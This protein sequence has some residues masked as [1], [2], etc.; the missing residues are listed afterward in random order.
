[1]NLPW[2]L[3]VMVFVYILAGINYFR[4]P[5]LYQ[6]IIPPYF[7]NPKLLNFISGFTEILL[8]IMLCFPAT[9]NLVALEIIALLMAFFTTHLY[10]Y[11]NEKAR[12][13]LPKRI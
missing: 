8:A 2:H 5:R 1:M 9:S 10:M 4:N 11:G 6:K 12:M 7:P 3:Y 13:G